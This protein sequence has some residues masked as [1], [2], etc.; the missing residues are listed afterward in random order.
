MASGF[1]AK[2]W[3]YLKVGQ[4][5]RVEVGS[6]SGVEGILLRDKGSDRLVLSVTVLQRSVSVE[7]DRAWIRPM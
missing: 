4:K 1:A 5:V 7:L 6:L 3:P 2:S